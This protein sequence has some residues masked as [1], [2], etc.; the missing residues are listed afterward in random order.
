MRNGI[1]ADALRHSSSHYRMIFGL[2]IPQLVDLAASLG[3]DKE[4]ALK[5]VDDSA[6]RESQLLA[7]MI[8]P[9]EEIKNQ[10]DALQW[11]S[12]LK[13]Q[14]AID[15][16]CLKLLKYYN[17]PISISKACL[18]QEDFLAKY[19]ALRLLW[20]IY[21]RFPKECLALLAD[22][23]FD[24]D[25]LLKSMADNLKEEIKYITVG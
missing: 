10:H 12:R 3:K 6:T 18:L 5:L 7:P 1:V 19:A 9:H 16:S 23:S 11:I 8:M 14:E 13:S 2:N 4:L 21:P 22:S 17:N 25:K 15:I 20:N 24:D